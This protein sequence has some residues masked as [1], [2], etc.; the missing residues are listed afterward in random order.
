LITLRES[1]G[2][3]GQVLAKNWLKKFTES[4]II[5]KIELKR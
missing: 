2:V 4:A 3:A 1:L 5:K